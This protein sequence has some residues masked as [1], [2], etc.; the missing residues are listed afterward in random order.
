MSHADH[1]TYVR[2][3][4]IWRQM[5][6]ASAP[7][8]KDENNAEL[9]LPDGAEDAHEQDEK[10][11]LVLQAVSSAN[12]L[13]CSTAATVC[14]CFPAELIW[15]GLRVV[16]GL[17]REMQVLTLSREMRV[18]SRRVKMLSDT[19]AGTEPSQF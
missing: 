16:L 4:V 19:A 10:M 18:L 15:D 14:V 8:E 11:E 13:V 17:W 3:H 6:K 9:A 5:L 12:F 7:A 2:A 1:G